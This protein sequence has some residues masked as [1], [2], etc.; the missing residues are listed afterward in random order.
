LVEAEQELAERRILDSKV[1]ALRDEMRA[2]LEFRRFQLTPQRTQ[3]GDTPLRKVDGAI[4][5]Q[6]DRW[7]LAP[8]E[9][10]A[11]ALRSVGREI[12][13]LHRFTDEPTGVT[14][15]GMTPGGVLVTIDVDRS[16]AQGRELGRTPVVG[17][18]PAPNGAAV[19]NGGNV[20]VFPADDAADPVAQVPASRPVFEV[21]DGSGDLWVVEA[22]GGGPRATT[23]RR[24]RP[25]A[26]ATFQAPVQVPLG[27]QVVGG[28]AGRLVL[29]DEAT[30]ALALYSP[31]TAGGAASTVVL[32]TGPA[33]FL[34]GDERRVLWQG[35]LPFGDSGSDGFL[36]LF[37]IATSAR[38]LLALPPTDAATGSLTDD[39]TIAI[40]AGPSAGRIG[41]V[42]VAEAGTAA[43][44][45]VEGP[46]SSV[47]GNAPRW[48]DDGQ[49]LFWLTPEG[50]VAMRRGTG[51]EARS[52]MVRTGL[53]GLS[54]LVVVDR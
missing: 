9:V 36:H 40:A 12:G 13:R 49:L 50:R 27:K 29:A 33:R 30:G 37:H 53:D 54:W 41:S 7:G 46:R 28:A 52:S 32:S 23:V 51:P 22:V 48:S 20:T 1:S 6:L 35:A 2:A 43:L 47:R 11:V 39:G 45:G 15:M 26:G 16:R 10:D 44:V 14:L 21:G 19:W 24:F 5:A 8:V 34:A 18:F 31:P 4:E 38:E 3:M 42:L 17:V 25:V